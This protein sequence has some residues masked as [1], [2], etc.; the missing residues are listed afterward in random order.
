MSYLSISPIVGMSRLTKV[1]NFF[2][3]PLA[4]AEFFVQASGNEELRDCAEFGLYGGACEPNEIL[5][6]VLD[7][8]LVRFLEESAG[9]IY[10][11]GANGQI[12]VHQM[13]VCGTVTTAEGHPKTEQVRERLRNSIRKRIGSIIHG[14]DEKEAALRYN[15]L[16]TGR[17]FRF[18]ATSYAF[19]RYERG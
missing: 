7:D 18:R 10:L 1:W 15:H 12:N 13:R 8:T 14:L 16:D 4:N 5:F 11:F 2:F 6:F 17:L 19:D 3:K 9:E